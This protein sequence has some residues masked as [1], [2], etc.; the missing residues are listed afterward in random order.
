MYIFTPR[1][2]R[3]SLAVV[4]MWLC[5]WILNIVSII[6]SYTLRKVSALTDET[7]RLIRITEHL[8]SMV[9]AA[10]TEKQVAKGA[11]QK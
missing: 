4:V 2:P 11:A 8:I 7:G 6:A 3:F 5:P 10:K 1:Y 9:E